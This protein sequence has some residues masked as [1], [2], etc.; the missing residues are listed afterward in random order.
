MGSKD[1]L[2]NIM[3]HSEYLLIIV[4][5]VVVFILIFSV[6]FKNISVSIKEAKEP[7]GQESN[8]T[9]EKE[10]SEAKE[11][12][13]MDIKSLTPPIFLE[14]RQ[15]LSIKTNMSAE[16]VYSDDNLHSNPIT[17]DKKTKVADGY[18]HSSEVSLETGRDYRYYV[19]CFSG[20]FSSEDIIEFS[21]RD[22]DEKDFEGENS[23]IPKSIYFGI[24]AL[25]LLTLDLVILTT[26]IYK[27][28]YQKNAGEVPKLQKEG[29]M[30]SAYRPVQ[31]RPALTRVAGMRKAPRARSRVLRGKIKKQMEGFI[32]L[33]E[34][35]KRYRNMLLKNIKRSAG[36]GKKDY[37][38]VFRKLRRIAG[39]RK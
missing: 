28:S 16:C 36:K 11:K 4:I 7:V 22:A 15:E 32:S 37:E 5:V 26:K 14:E 39:N 18:V 24:L 13:R 21:V 9:S 2:S 34:F 10:K 23:K 38:K 19:L 3:V 6:I 29:Q 33:S 30:G 12:E 17:F 1:N 27:K 8:E 25:G 35:Q 31:A 20:E